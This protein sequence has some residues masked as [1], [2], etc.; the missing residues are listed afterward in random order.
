MR[1]YFFMYVLRDYSDIM[2]SMTLSFVGMGVHYRCTSVVVQITFEENIPPLEGGKLRDD[3][4][5]LDSN[6]TWQIDATN[7]EE[8]D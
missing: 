1:L 8:V 2:I 3:F 5:L 6:K 7:T 4:Y